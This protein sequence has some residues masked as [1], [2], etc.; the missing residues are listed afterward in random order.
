[1]NGT[2]NYSETLASSLATDAAA[3]ADKAE[4]LLSNASSEFQNFIADVEDLVKETSTLT[5]ED[6]KRAKAK[7]SARL[8]SARSSAGEMGN[9]IAKR[10]RQAAHVTNDYVH[11]QPWKAIGAGAAVG[12]LIGFAL[13]RR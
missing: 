5:G 9:A 10:S 12:L 8:E 2:S 13:A 4:S 6:L 3:A 1:M 7:L 11:E